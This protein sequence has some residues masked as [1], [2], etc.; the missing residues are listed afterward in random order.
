MNKEIR[1]AVDQLILEQGEYIPLELL[2]AEGRLAYDDYEAW[3]AGDIS[4]LD[5]VLFGDP[6]QLAELLAEAEEYAKALHLKPEQLSYQGWGTA[7]AAVLSYSDNRVQEERFHTAYRRQA[8]QPQMDLFIDA[9]ASRL[10]NGIVQSLIGR[11]YAEARRLLDRLFEAD[12]GHPRLGALE[13]MIEA[14]SRLA[15]PVHDCAH[16]LEFLQ[17]TLQPMAERELG[18]ESNS[19]LVPHWRRLTAA[20]QDRPFDPVL[21]EMHASFT[22]AQAFDWEG[23]IS[24]VESVAAWPDQPLLIV[25]HAYA[26]GRL[27][28]EILALQGWF[29]LCWS[30]PDHVEAMATEPDLGRAW[31]AFSALEPELSPT[32]FPSWL[33][34]QRPGLTSQLPLPDSDG[35]AP[36]SYAL[37]HRLQRE[38][39]QSGQAPD[40]KVI[41]RRRKLQ[42]SAPS[43]F[44]HYMKTKVG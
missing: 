3:R 34:L 30:F 12:P 17:Q 37:I 24:A 13:Q 40:K 39:P 14:G 31:R 27:R 42:A 5:Q 8:L 7:A 18:R 28:R 16:E 41:E 22:A 32:D 33:L 26:C 20:L 29:Q 36:P 38:P 10:V 1:D 35:S 19:L 23:V 2:L 43:L 44:S 6:T 25:R 15:E 21:P 9:T 11:D 4:R